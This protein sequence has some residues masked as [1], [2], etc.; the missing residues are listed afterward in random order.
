MFAALITLTAILCA[1]QTLSAPPKPVP[2]P[3]PASTPTPARDRWLALVDEMQRWRDTEWPEDAIANG[4]FT[5]CPD[6]ITDV[7]IVGIEKRHAQEGVYL[8]ELMEIDP[9]QLSGD[10]LLGWQLITRQMRESQDGHRFRA[11]LMPIGVVMDR[12]KTFRKWLIACHFAP[13]Q[14]VTITSSD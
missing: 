9:A 11:F 13:Q 14:T 2:V 3:V 7:S 10:D 1:P 4:R 8:T 6:R 5:P 12:S